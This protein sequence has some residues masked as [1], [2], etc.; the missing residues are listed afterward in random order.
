MIA[1]KLTFSQSFRREKRPICVAAF[2]FNAFLEFECTISKKLKARSLP[3]RQDDC[4]R[5]NDPTSAH[6]IRTRSWRQSYTYVSSRAASY[7]EIN[8][9]TKWLKHDIKNKCK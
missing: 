3:D 5:T 2:V 1:Q 4:R 8:E 7:V 9:K 6:P